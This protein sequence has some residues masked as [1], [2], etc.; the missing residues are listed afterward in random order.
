[1]RSKM[2]KKSACHRLFP[3]CS[4]NTYGAIRAR[5]SQ[6]SSTSSKSSSRDRLRHSQSMPFRSSNDTDESGRTKPVYRG[7]H[8]LKTS[9]IHLFVDITPAATNGRDDD[10]ELTDDEDFGVAYPHRAPIL[11]RRVLDS[12]PAPP[13][14]NAY[15]SQTVRSP[16]AP[17]P[18]F[19]EGYPSAA[20]LLILPPNPYYERLARENEK[21]RQAQSRYPNRQRLERN[22]STGSSTSFSRPT[23]NAYP[24][25]HPIL[26]IHHRSYT[27]PPDTYRTSH[28]NTST[29]SLGGNA[30]LRQGP[31]AH[32]PVVR[33]ASIPHIEPPRP[34]KV[35]SNRQPPVPSVEPLRPRKVSTNS[36]A[37][38]AQRLG[39]YH[40]DVIRVVRGPA[41]TRLQ[42]T[43]VSAQSAQIHYD[44]YEDPYYANARTRA[45]VTVHG[46][47]ATRF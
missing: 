45:P 32:R 29:H 31:T 22:T 13:D 20:D 5:P 44:A 33:Q 47:S 17:R 14:N 37:P 8:P 10:A 24:G 28:N 18:V 12:F 6:S 9:D 4:T 23:R 43:P 19:N 41:R 3:P 15:S 11:D 2:F 16:C 39:P 27:H 34:R 30:R 42:S 21:I 1:M 26:P 40:P 25:I 46:R 35:L 38:T 7:V 36:P